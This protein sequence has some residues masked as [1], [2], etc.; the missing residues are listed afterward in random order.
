MVVMI[1]LDNSRRSYNIKCEWYDKKVKLSDLQKLDHNIK[2]TGI[3]YAREHQPSNKTE[4][5]END[6]VKIDLQNTVIET[7]DDVKG[8]NH[9]CLVKYNGELWIVDNV[10]SKMINKRSE[11]DKRPAR[12]SWIALRNRGE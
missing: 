3:F 5:F 11:F 10:Q 9:E 4:Q 2:P 1:N 7:Q 12:I 8:I 6:L